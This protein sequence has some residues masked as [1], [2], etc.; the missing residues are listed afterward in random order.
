[1]VS[2]IGIESQN[3]FCPEG[4]EYI[5]SLQD[6]SSFIR[7]LWLKP[8]AI[9]LNPFRIRHQNINAFEEY[10]R[11]VADIFVKDAKSQKLPIAKCFK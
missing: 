10:S 11:A 8:Q 5:P 1:M 9:L 6:E 4:A 3:L 2:T 7:N